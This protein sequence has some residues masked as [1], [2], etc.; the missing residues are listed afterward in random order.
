VKEAEQGLGWPGHE[1]RRDGYRHDTKHGKQ[2]GNSHF[3]TGEKDGSSYILAT[4]QVNVD[5]FEEDGAFINENTYR[6]GKTTERH[7]VDRLPGEFEK[8]DG[9]QESEWN[10]DYDNE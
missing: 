5:V 9:G 4:V 10:G 7:N 8:D 6:E 2:S 3:L 1:E